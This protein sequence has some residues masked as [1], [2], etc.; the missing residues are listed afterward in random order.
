MERVPPSSRT[1]REPERTAARHEAR[2]SNGLN[3][4]LGWLL[5]FGVVLSV[6]G[7]AFVLSAPGPSDPNALVSSG[8]E[9]GAAQ[10]SRFESF[11]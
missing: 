6:A 7:G 10:G 5:L 1:V 2:A 9:P 11:Q 3:P 4:L 8:A